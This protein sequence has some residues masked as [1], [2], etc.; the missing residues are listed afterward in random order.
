MNGD[1]HASSGPSTIFRT[2]PAFFA[3]VKICT[4]MGSV[5]EGPFYCVK[6]DEDRDCS[7]N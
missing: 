2:N 5:R 6:T 4:N 7:R 3:R 1:N